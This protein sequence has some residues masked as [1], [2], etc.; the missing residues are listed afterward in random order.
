M[1]SREE[2]SDLKMQMEVFH[3]SLCFPLLAVD[4]DCTL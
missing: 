4:Y 2:V 1:D 3:V